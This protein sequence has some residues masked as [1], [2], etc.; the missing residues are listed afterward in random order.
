MNYLACS[1]KY[2][3]FVKLMLLLKQ[4]KPNRKKPSMPHNL[5]ALTIKSADLFKFREIIV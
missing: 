2:L 3:S 4:T 5:N 1:S